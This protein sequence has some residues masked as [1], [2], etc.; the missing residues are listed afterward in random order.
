MRIETYENMLNQYKKDGLSL[1]YTIELLQERIEYLSKFS[2]SVIVE[3]NHD[4]FDSLD[5]WME[6]NSWVKDKIKI[7]SFEN[8][9]YGKTGYDYGF[10]EF[11][12]NDKILFNS[13]CKAIPNIYTCFPVSI[14]KTDGY[15]NFID[16]D[17]EY[18][19]ALIYKLIE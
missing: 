14:S 2:Y 10:G 16:L 8:L 6:N 11:F 12:M 3:G 15:G 5:Q 13:L 9:Y 4:E 17:P 1:K 19:Q 18:K 7:V